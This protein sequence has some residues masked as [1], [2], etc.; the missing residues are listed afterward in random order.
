MSVA[1]LAQPAMSDDLIRFGW[2]GFEPGIN[3]SI[4][5]GDTKEKLLRRFGEPR[6]LK[7][8]KEPHKRDPTVLHVEVY[9]W[10]WE[11]LEIIT[12]RLILYEG[13]DDPVQFVKEITLTSPKYKLK[14]GLSIGAPRAAFIDKLGR[15]HSEGPKAAMEYET[16]FYAGEGGATFVHRPYISIE[17]DA[18]QLA[19]K[20]TW[21][22]F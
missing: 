12:T 17:F 11:G 10:Q 15:P 19:K 6:E 8:R 2:D 21:Q 5:E 1:L 18:E 22:Y 20:I 4:G 3:R 7:M 14:F 9:T 13:Y 16:E